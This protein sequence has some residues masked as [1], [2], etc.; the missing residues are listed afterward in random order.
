MI[1][2]PVSASINYTYEEY[3]SFLKSTDLVSYNKF[4]NLTDEQKDIFMSYIN[5][6]EK[7][8]EDLDNPNS[9][10]NY[11]I[12]KSEET[13]VENQ[14]S[15][16]ANQTYIKN[17]SFSYTQDIFWID[18]LI[19]SSYLKYSHDNSKIIN[20]LWY[21]TYVDRNLI[22]WQDFQ[23][24]NKHAYLLNSTV[25]KYVSDVTLK[26]IHKSFWISIITK[27]FWLVGWMHWKIEHW[28]VN[29]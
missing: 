26:L 20:I 27:E 21:D 10:I 22:L 25:V 3:W 29:K 6:P 9:P 28:A 19:I 14:L 23:I 2:T 17:I 1:I 15:R 7:I 16:S 12:E 13:I 11:R 18:Y 24:N 4:I 5:N 8:Q